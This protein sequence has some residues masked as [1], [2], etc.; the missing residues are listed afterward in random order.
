MSDPSCRKHRH[1]LTVAG[2]VALSAVFALTVNAQTSTGGTNNGA[3]RFTGG[4]DVPSVYVFR[5]ILQETDPRL[6]IAPYGDIGLA[7]HSGAGRFKTVGV[8]VGVWNSLQTGSSGSDGPSGH[9]HYRE[10]FHA[11][12]SMGFGG[13]LSISAGYAAL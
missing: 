6:T 4:V 9:L 10:D 5:G 12:F 1:V 3:I 13:G 2:G 11:A 8:N 7:L